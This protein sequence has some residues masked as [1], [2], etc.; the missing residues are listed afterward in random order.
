[1]VELVD[2][3]VSEASAERL[4]G[5]S[6]PLRTTKSKVQ[7]R[8]SQNTQ[9]NSRIIQA[10]AAWRG[11]VYA[12]HA[13]ALALG[14][15]AALLGMVIGPALQVL[16]VPDRDRLLWSEVLGPVW[17]G[18]F[19]QYLGADGIQVKVI[20]FYLPMVLVV[21]ATLKSFLTIWQWYTWEWLGEQIAFRWR[22]DLV[23]AFVALK[24]ELRDRSAVAKTEEGLGGLMTQDIRTCRDY[25]VH[26]F[27]G[28]PRE[29]F[30]AIFMA[31]SIAALSP[32][33][34]FVFALCL[35]PVVALLSRLG[36]KIRR[37][38]TQALEDNSVLGEWIQ[39]RLLGVE[40]IK[41]YG[42]EDSEIAAMKSASENLFRG[43][44]KAARSKARTGPIIEILGV[45]A[46]CVALGVA[47]AEIST[48]RISG[49]VAMS[50]FA[51]L[52]LFAQ[53]AAKLGRYFNSNR[54]GVAAAARIFSAADEFKNSSLDI[55]RPIQALEA[56]DQIRIEL[57]DVSVNYGASVA[58]NHVTLTFEAGRVYC[59]VG[60]S[61][62]GKSSLFAAILGL[63]SP[64]AGRI[65]YTV[66][67][68]FAGGLDISYMPQSV[69]T[70]PGSIAENV[71]YPNSKID[72]LKVEKALD[73]VGFRLDTHRLTNGFETLVGPGEL[74]LSG[75]EAQRLQLARLIYHR[76]PYILIDEGTSA[77]DPGL[78]K[79][80]LTRAR[81]L[82]KAGSVVVMIAHRPAAVDFADEVVVMHNG[83]V[84]RVGP[85]T[86]VTASQEFRAVFV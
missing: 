21:V 85:R 84:V 69:T 39:Q 22:Q 78:E 36:R 72:L 18:L 75:G 30:Q 19:H 38:S 28:L 26:F 47:F 46:M 58:V 14:L 67:K 86:D 12:A 27:G 13:A 59:I 71:A 64:G 68:T 48:G 66:D 23:A 1:M 76:S 9:I 32:K 80:V 20:Y 56:S 83:R 44:L 35:A 54:E 65:K 37:R 34:F 11:R 25:V 41:Q 77:L 57:N 4:G 53:S 79:L 16:I 62:A 3:L 73:A 51:S 61:G 82:A 74:Q 6:P 7:T 31:I 8:K 52:A 50:F 10:L 17:S 24:P 43:F 40:T 5:S 2:T 63:V 60:S 33:L 55:V 15:V 42:T 81:E 45:T 29:G 70:F 49:A